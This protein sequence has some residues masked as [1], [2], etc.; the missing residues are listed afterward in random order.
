MNY[1]IN[2]EQFASK[3]ALQRRI[4]TILNTR[5]GEVDGEHAPFLLSLFRRHRD[6]EQKFGPGVAAIRVVLAMPYK[7]RCFEIERVDGTRTD[8]SY[9]ECLKPSTVFEWFPAACR[10]AVVDQIQAF[11]DSAFGASHWVNCAVTGDPVSRDNCHVD[12]EP[13]WTFEAIVDSF[14]DNSV[15]DLAQLEFMDGDGETQ[16]RFADQSLADSFARYHAERAQLRVVTRWA[17]LS[18][19][20]KASQT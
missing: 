11:K 14:L 3:A 12:H 9:L 8:I 17:N 19:L 13:P 15:I 10:T 6:A 20:R 16:S 5:L 18:L 7:T 4:R 1:E 2:G